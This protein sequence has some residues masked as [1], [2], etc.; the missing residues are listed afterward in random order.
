MK[1]PVGANAILDTLAREPAPPRFDLW[2]ALNDLEP[3]GRDISWIWDADFEAF[4]PRVRG[5][6]C[7]GRR[8]PELALRLRYAGWPV[9]LADV[10]GDLPRSFARAVARAPGELVALPTYTALLQLEAALEDH[11]AASQE[12]AASAPRLVAT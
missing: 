1:N 8:A 7:S 3:D 6:S 5:V 9:D 2:L 12:W 11:G 10:D 4:A